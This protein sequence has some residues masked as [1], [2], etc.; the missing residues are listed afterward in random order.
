MP[1]II[2]FNAPP[3]AGKDECAKYLTNLVNESQNGKKATHMEFKAQ[4]FEI[5][6]AFFGIS[7]EEYKKGYDLSTEEVMG[8]PFGKTHDPEW[9]KDYPRFW[10][11]DSV[12]PDPKKSWYSERTGLIHVSENVI[13]PFFGEKAFGI[14]LANSIP[15]EI[16]YVFVS[17]SGFPQELQGVVDKFGHD[18]ITVIRLY[19]ED[20]SFDNDSRDYLQPEMFDYRIKFIDIENNYDTLED[21]HE[22]LDEVMLYE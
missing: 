7:V 10:V 15:E 22:V 3:R 19:R 11:T 21:L 17:D 4:L 6:A 12:Y 5:T 2:V 18:V 1:K 14:M 13:K 9:F 20:C 8:P 16:D